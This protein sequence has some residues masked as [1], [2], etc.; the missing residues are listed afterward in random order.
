MSGKNVVEAQQFRDF[1]LDKIAVGIAHLPPPML[2]SASS[3]ADNAHCHL[4]SKI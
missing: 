1:H 4:S 3:I 2:S